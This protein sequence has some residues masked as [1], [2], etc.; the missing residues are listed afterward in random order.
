MCKG[1]CYQQEKRCENGHEWTDLVCRKIEDCRNLDTHTDQ[2]GPGR[3]QVLAVA[4]D[5]CKKDKAKERTYMGES[6]RWAKRIVDQ[7]VWSSEEDKDEFAAKFAEQ[8]FADYVR[9]AAKHKGPKRMRV[10]R[11]REA[12]EI[13]RKAIADFGQQRLPQDFTAV[14]RTRDE[15]RSRATRMQKY[16]RYHPKRLGPDSEKKTLISQGHDSEGNGPRVLHDYNYQ[17]TSPGYPDIDFEVK[18]PISRGHNSEGDDS[19]G[20]ITDSRQSRALMGGRSSSHVAEQTPIGYG[21][22]NQGRSRASSRASS[23][24]SDE[25]WKKFIESSPS[26]PSV[27]ASGSNSHVQRQLTPNTADVEQMIKDAL[28]GDRVQRHEGDQ[29]GTGEAS[30]KPLGSSYTGKGKGRANDSTASRTHS[31]SST[32]V[33]NNSF[34]EEPLPAR[35][36]PSP[37]HVDTTAHHGGSPDNLLLKKSG[38]DTAHTSGP[39]QAFSSTSAGRGNQKQPSQS[40]MAAPRKSASSNAPRI[41]SSP[42]PTHPS[43]SPPVTL[44]DARA[45]AH[46][47]VRPQTPHVQ[48]AAP[49]IPP[50]HTAAGH[51]TI[52]N[53]TAGVG[54]GHVTGG[55]SSKSGSNTQK[56]PVDDRNKNKKPASG[57]K[58]GT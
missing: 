48:H 37:P 50:A 47:A 51:I 30:T 7:N 40:Q 1:E 9:R 39:G 14:E 24:E 2:K 3:E 54:R 27:F 38:T 58:P 5:R 34:D 25:S 32:S 19:V 28:G 44:P 53:P 17:E 42:A 4:C 57:K 55:V 36:K 26:P 15:S 6:R 46:P 13:L 23:K 10:I 41:G 11:Q 21:T 8:V 49:P 12:D 16:Q 33:N 29:L 52:G 31:R 45:P 18:S 35:T 22:N 56:K 20:S 43:L